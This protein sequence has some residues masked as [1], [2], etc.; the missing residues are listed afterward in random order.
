MFVDGRKIVRDDRHAEGD[1]DD[2]GQ[3]ADT[4]DDPAGPGARDE[5]SVAESRQRTETPV[6]GDRYVGELR[7]ALVE[8]AFEVED[9]NGEDERA[10][11][12]ERDE[13]EDLVDAGLEGVN[14]QAEG[15]GQA[16]EVDDVKETE[17]DEHYQCLTNNRDDVTNYMTS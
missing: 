7:Q 15:L 17:D 10:D 1:G 2:A 13:D 6:E 12:D 4:G 5:I 3:T 9:E 16:H 11:A 14:E 8:L